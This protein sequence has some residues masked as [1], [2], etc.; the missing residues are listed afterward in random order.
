LAEDA[1]LQ[2]GTE[3]AWDEMRLKVAALIEEVMKRKRGK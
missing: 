1:Q 3:T 2:Y